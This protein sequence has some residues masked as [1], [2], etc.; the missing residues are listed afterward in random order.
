MAER[1]DRELATQAGRNVVF[2]ECCE[3]RRIVGGVYYH[4]DVLVILRRRTQH[5]GAADIDVLD[6]FCVG[7]VGSRRRRFEWVQI[8]DQKIDDADAVLGEHR[9]VDAAAREQT[10]VNVRMQ[11]LYAAIHDFG[12]AR[13]RCD[14]GHVDAGLAQRFGRTT[15]GDELVAER[16]KA[17][18]ERFQAL[19]VGHAE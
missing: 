16:R 14:L 2:L 4:E 15:R 18:G 1:F 8:H 12:K 11:R 6:G 19:L 9:V 10:T 17:L 13:D 3:H 5:G 7:A